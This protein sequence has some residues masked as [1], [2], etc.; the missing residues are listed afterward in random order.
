MGNFN[1][2]WVEIFRAGNYGDKGNWTPE[3]ID[4]VVA[5]LEATNAEGQRLHTPMAVFGH[6][7]HDD[8]AHAAV[9]ALKREGEIL[10]AKFTKT[11][12]HL[13]KSVQDGRFPN[14]SAAFY[15]DP[16]GCGPI[17]R[18]VGFLG[19]MPPEVKGLAPVQFFDGG[20]YVS[21]DF[22]EETV[23]NQNPEDTKRGIREAVEGFFADMFKKKT[24]PAGA[25]FTEAQLQEKI[26]AAAQKLEATFQEK[27]DELG[28]KF[29]ERASTD[30]GEKAKLKVAAFVEKMRAAKRW[31]P[32]FEK[33]RMRQAL[34]FLES[35]ETFTFAEKDAKGVEQQ[36]NFGR[37]E[38]AAALITFLESLP[39]LIPFGE[40][41]GQSAFAA[42]T[43]QPINT[44]HTEPINIDR[45]QRAQAL[46]RESRVKNPEKPLSYAQARQVV[47]EEEAASGLPTT[48]A[49]GAAAGGV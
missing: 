12:D 18:H 36:V 38:A 46:I 13:E 25:S 47:M 37:A 49:G 48:P 30:D 20:D 43:G 33:G 8:P 4:Q 32:A 39:P 31:L 40:L 42:A 26:A 44:R 14:R 17:L 6:P 41:A 10:L 35:G 15:L 9:S 5:N 22:K 1:N 11:S 23:S 45:A 24:D 21:I 29:K 27:L 16:Q 28:K 19:A 3:K 7:K 34:Q 2:Q